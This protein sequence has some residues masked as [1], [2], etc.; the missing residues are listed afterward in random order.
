MSFLTK[1]AKY[2]NGLTD[3]QKMQIKQRK[4]DQMEN[5]QRLAK[6]QETRNLDKPKRPIS[7]YLMFLSTCRQ[8]DPVGAD[9]SYGDWIAKA[10][11]KW[12]ALTDAEKSKFSD[13]VKKSRQTYR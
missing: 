3:E 7:A 10:T 13:A 9:Q 1:R 8:T 4:Q 6:R 11:K 5:R 12:Y 2:E